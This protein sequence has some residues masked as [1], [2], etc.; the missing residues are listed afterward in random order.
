MKVYT[1]GGDEGTT[2]LIGGVRVA[3]IDSRVEAYGTVDELTAF[4]ALLGDKLCLN[5]DMC[6]LYIGDLNKI[7][8]TLMTV[9]AHL[10][11][12][13]DSAKTLPEISDEV[14][15]Y[16]E[17]RIDDLQEGLKPLDKFTIPGG[18]VRVSLCHVCRTICRRAERRAIAAKYEFPIN[19]KVIVYL[20][21]LSDYLYVL[22]R[23]LTADF[24][25]EEILWV[26]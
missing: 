12:D 14:V 19:P 24:E 8:S 9:E 18:D 21:R 20:N 17:S 15:E 10:A 13:E 2:S 3:K 23:A 6:S 16:L 11:C 25:V 1:K 26:P 22:G 4:I 7:N 5:R